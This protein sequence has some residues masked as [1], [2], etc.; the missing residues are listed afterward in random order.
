[1]KFYH[2]TPVPAAESILSSSLSRGH[3]YLPDGE[4]RR[5]VV[6]LTSD[7]RPW[8]HGLPD[9]KVAPTV[10]Q[11]RH[12]ELVQG[13]P[14]KNTVL[15]DHTA[16]RLTLDL[17]EDLPGLVSFRKFALEFGGRDY[18]RGYGLSAIY[19]IRNLT[20]KQFKQ[21]SRT[22]VTKEA[23]WWL[24]FVPIPPVAIKAVDF[25]EQGNFVPYDFEV[26]GRKAMEE[27]GI[28]CPG[29]N[30]LDEIRAIVEPCHP[31]EQPKA[32]LICTDPS[33]EPVV[34]IRGLALQKGDRI[35]SIENTPASSSA[36]ND[37]DRQLLE[38]TSRH[39]DELLDCWR[40]AVE[41]YYAY[42][43]EKTLLNGTS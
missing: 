10:E 43:P 4:L 31:L 13:G 39:K 11:V 34:V 35:I 2:F 23:T 33:A 1:M 5:G 25:N 7:H 6:W 32:M 19:S 41:R 17:P 37:I 21:A 36:T 14:L 12:L 30:A 15:S 29:R 38:W 20:P 22:A 42:Y 27:S 16:I 3:L 24:S 8:G 18:L 9:G 40:L 28:T 26:H